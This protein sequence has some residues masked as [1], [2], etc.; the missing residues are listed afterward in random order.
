MVEIHSEHRRKPL[1]EGLRNGYFSGFKRVF[2]I[3]F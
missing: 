3:E 1:Y 2:E